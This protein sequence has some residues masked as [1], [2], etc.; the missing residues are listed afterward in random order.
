MIDPAADWHTHSSLTDGADTP[1]RMARAAATSGLSLWGLSDHVRADSTWVADYVRTVRALDAG[2]VTV[3]CGVEAKILDRQGTLDLPPDVRDLDY[4]LVADHQFPG[5]DGPRHPRDVRAA[6]ETGRLDGKD[7]IE[8]LVTAT[9][10]AAGRSPFPAIIAHLFSLLPK[11]G[12]SEDDVS[13][14]VVLGL[15]RELA[16]DGA[17]VE[18]NEKWSCPSDRV[19][20]LLSDAGVEL[21]AG[22]DAHRHEDIGR[23]TY[24]DSL[25]LAATVRP[26]RE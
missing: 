1:E 6:I 13:D 18:A 24:L 5:A 17:R 9:A 25:E 23:H 12:L 4:V 14:D 21:T 19:L 15:G 16:A 8:Q 2:D 26:G 11:C 7:A 3:R 10:K 22:S 20:R